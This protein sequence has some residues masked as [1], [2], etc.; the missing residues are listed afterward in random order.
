MLELLE[1]KYLEIDQ[2]LIK[3]TQ[4]LSTTGKHVSDRKGLDGRYEKDNR[5]QEYG[6]RQ[7]T[8]GQTGH[9]R[10]ELPPPGGS[11]A[12]L[13]TAATF[14]PQRRRRRRSRREEEEKKKKKTY[15]RISSVKTL[16]YG[17]FG[18]FWK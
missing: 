18:L 1:N 2:H 15:S 8:F 5:K 3:C 6:P 14:K 10:S 13:R 17:P 11:N 7:R 9:C 12:A 16:S 4:L